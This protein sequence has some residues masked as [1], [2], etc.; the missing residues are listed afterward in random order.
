MSFLVKHLGFNLYLNSSSK[1]KTS[2]CCFY[3]PFL[4]PR[5]QKQWK[6]SWKPHRT[7]PTHRARYLLPL[8]MSECDACLLKTRKETT[9][10]K[11]APCYRY[12]CR[13]RSSPPPPPPVFTMF[14]FNEG[15]G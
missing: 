2:E 11:F 6:S 9:A 15:R 13:C 10:G 4:H 3:P 1:S 14:M 8:N 7:R 12:P 5:Q